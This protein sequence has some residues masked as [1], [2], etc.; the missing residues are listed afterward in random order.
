MRV[1]NSD[2]MSLFLPNMSFYFIISQHPRQ[3]TNI[4]S[5][6]GLSMSNAAVYF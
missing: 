4:L 1:T 2:E 5:P 3:E 6:E